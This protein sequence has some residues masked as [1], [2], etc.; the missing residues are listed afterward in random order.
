M[1]KVP[2][3][4]YG[5]STD[6]NTSSRLPG[7][8]I[9]YLEVIII[10]SISI[11]I[12]L[13]VY[14]P[15]LRDLSVPIEGD[16]RAHIFKIDILHDYLSH[17]SWPQWNPYW[18]HGF[19][20]FQYYPPGFYF[21]GA[22]LTFVTGYAVVS[23]KLLL[24][25]ALISNGLA[26]YYFSRK[27]LKLN[28]YLSILCLV[29]YQS[30]TALLLNYIYGT[31]PNLIG[32]SLCVIFLTLYLRNVTEGKV[33]GL[34]PIVLPGLLF[35]MTVLIHPYPAIFGVLAIIIFHIIWLAR[36]HHP[37]NTAK[38]Q[39]PYAIYVLGIGALLA[40]HYWLPF[41]L[42]R[43]YVSP[44]YT[45]TTDG[46]R[47]GVPFLLLLIL[48]ALILGSITRWKITRDIRLDLLIAYVI[49]ALALGFGLSRYL[50]LGS[51]L[52]E[53]RFATIV[54][55][56]FSIL[57]V[58]FSLNVIP[59][60]VRRRKL[61]IVIVSICLVL[62][63]SVFPFI[64]TYNSA[65]LNR[66]FLYV[67]NY[68]QPDYAQLLESAKNGRLIVPTAKGYL[69]EGDSLVTFGWHYNVETVNG[70]Y[71]QGDPKF[72]KHTV[73]LEWEERWFEYQ[74]TRENLMHESAAQYIFIRDTELPPANMNGLRC[75][76]DNSYGQLWELEEGVAHAVSVTPILLDVDNEELVT[77]FFNI[78]LPKGY[79]M[80]FVNVDG[81]DKHLKKEFEYVMVDDE[82][83]LPDYEGKSIFLLNNTEQSSNL[84]TD[85]G[86][87]VV[88]LNLPYVTYTNQFFYHGD[89]G[90]VSAWRDFDSDLSSRLQ[91]EAFM[92]LQQAGSAIDEYLQPLKYKPVD[93]NFDGTKIELKAEP[94]FILVKDSYFPYWSTEQG[95]ILSTS[96][97]FMLVYTDDATI[98]LSYKKPAI[99]TAA[100]T[101]SIV[102]LVTVVI[103]LAISTFRQRNK[104]HT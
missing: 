61:G 72:F 37:L 22:I 44:I 30:S 82:S 38:T 10:V 4:N 85:K 79:R 94:G 12:A 95:R 66:L 58:A 6:N 73:H 99:N 42:T 87:K 17:G 62:T 43:D 64:S 102:G 77:E 24:F 47:G 96:Q 16:V 34:T 78:L 55:P 71:N 81:V 101:T 91:G 39:L 48:L 27:F 74:F 69:T 18:Y 35:G 9:S 54:A 2:W 23:Y 104:S 26:A 92:M 13:A 8:K 100:T 41:W 59:A 83:K 15:H 45:F 90:D 31:V 98:L 25:L 63:T 51:L 50:P 70:A 7:S 5:D 57:L 14:A 67:Q 88:K 56:F 97:G 32:W 65:N 19:P 49:L 60:T 1:T 93:Y 21:L 103:V 68:R 86:G 52:H 53:F 36:S 29:A 28:I 33:H 89:K 20:A 11:A 40:S 76:I 84:V 46:W 75:I 3:S 80:V